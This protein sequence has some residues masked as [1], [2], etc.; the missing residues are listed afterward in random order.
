MISFKEMNNLI[1]MITYINMI[2]TINIIVSFYPL[3]LLNIIH[4]ILYDCQSKNSDCLFNI[5]ILMLYRTI[6]DI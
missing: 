6:Q 1:H 5:F 2:I 4:V 3:V